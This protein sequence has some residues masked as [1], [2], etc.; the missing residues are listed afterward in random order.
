MLFFKENIAILEKSRENV[1]FNITIM[2]LNLVK[3]S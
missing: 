3:L 1:R 2:D